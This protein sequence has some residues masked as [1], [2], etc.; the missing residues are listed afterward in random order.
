MDG[1]PKVFARAIAPTLGRT[2]SPAPPPPPQPEE[3]PEEETDVFGAIHDLLEKLFDTTDALTARLDAMEAR[4]AG[5]AGP[6]GRYAE[7]VRDD[8]GRIIGIAGFGLKE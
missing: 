7:L 2:T 1:D 3:P 8:N 5:A 4:I 6:P